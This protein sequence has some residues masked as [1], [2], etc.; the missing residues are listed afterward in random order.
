MGHNREPDH[1]LQEVVNDE[2]TYKA[3]L[4]RGPVLQRLPFKMR[5]DGR[6]ICNPAI[7]A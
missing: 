7:N 3:L 4:R 2:V 5:K 6:A 1:A